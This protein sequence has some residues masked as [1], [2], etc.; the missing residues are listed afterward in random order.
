SEP[1][2]EVDSSLLSTK[3]I[4]SPE[5]QESIPLLIQGMTCASCVSSVEKALLSVDGIDKA[6]VNLAEQSALVFTRSSR[7]D[8]TNALLAAVKQ[9]GYQAEV[10]LDAELTQQ[11]QSEQMMQAQR[12][13]KVSAFAGIALGAP[14]MLWGVL[15]GSMSIADSQDQIAWGV[16]G[17]VCL[18]LLATAGKSFFTNAWLALTHKRATM[19]T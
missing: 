12:K 1:T 8:L 2:R 6:Q 10:V 11:K 18:L 9:S 7:A 15:G 4:T 13:H 17:L 19:D 16:V 3:A 5:L 14:L